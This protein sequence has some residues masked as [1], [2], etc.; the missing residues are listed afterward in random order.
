MQ[1]WESNLTPLRY[2]INMT[3]EFINFLHFFYL[4]L[5]IWFVYNMTLE[6]Y[7]YPNLMWNF[8]HNTIF[9]H[10]YIVFI[11]VFKNCL[12]LFS[13]KPSVLTS[14]IRICQSRV[15]PKI[16]A[17]NLTPPSFK[18]RLSCGKQ[19]HELLLFSA[20]P[21]LTEIAALAGYDIIVVDLK[22]GPGDVMDALHCIRAITAACS[23]S[24][25]RIPKITSAWAKK[26]SRWDPTR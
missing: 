21:T 20:S 9:L 5:L 8:W 25:I 7:L 17:T 26:H 24:V 18:S 4:I 3:C 14:L 1:K 22:H 6:Y 11:F 10:R 19:L 23:S 2:N 16:L 13:S 12:P 15:F